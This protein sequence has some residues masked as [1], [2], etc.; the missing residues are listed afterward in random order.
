MSAPE[1][2]TQTR[3]GF[4]DWFDLGCLEQEEAAINGLI[5]PYKEC[6]ARSKEILS[7]RFSESADIDCLLEARSWLVDRV[8]IDCWTRFMG[9]DAGALSL[10]AVGGYGRSELMPGSDVDLLLLVPEGKD[11]R[12]DRKLETLLTF[13]WD[14]G[15]EVGHSVRTVADCVEQSLT[16]I[17]VITNLLES[18]LLAG[19]R[20]L[21]GA[22]LLATGPDHIWNS[23]EYFEAKLDEQHAR[24]HRY[25]DTGYNLEPNIKEG[26]GGLR[27]IQMITWVTMRHLGTASLEQLVERN[28]LTTDEYRILVA[29]RELLWRIRF[30]LHTLTGRSEDRLLFDY[31]RSLAEKFGYHNNEQRLG[32]EAF[33]REYYRTIM[34]LSRLNEM[35]LQLFHE[36]ILYPGGP[37][38]P[39]PINRR[40]QSRNGYLEIVHANVF[41][42]NRF[43]LL[44]IFLTLEQHPELRGVRADTI[45][46]IRSHQ[47][48]IDDDF[49]GDI[50]ARS[51]FMEIMRQP[52]GLT[53]ELRR[54]NVYGILAAY[55]PAFG[56]IIGLMQ[57][58][59]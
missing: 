19:S 20:D 50:R 56:N 35:L 3:P 36:E 58:D 54:M 48:L 39:A 51:L 17:T 29:G 23:R 55:L 15:L 1:A 33:M 30:A 31:Q 40:F 28:F 11:P 10:V 38:E 34:E 46:A 5:K 52:H 32:V 44:E 42:H 16:D 24:H 37:A 8:L 2:N 41:N 43:A 14:I 21:Y 59:L 26:P 22:M 27:D 7:D 49:R 12:I 47:H 57:Y 4:S 13:L 18:R 25:H 53:H 9:D 45:R 6:L